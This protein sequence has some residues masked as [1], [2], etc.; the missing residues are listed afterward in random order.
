M[1]NSRAAT[2]RR[3][4]AVLKLIYSKKPN[5]QYANW[6]LDKIFDQAT[7]KIDMP[8]LTATLLQWCFDQGIYPNRLQLSSMLWLIVQRDCVNGQKYVASQNP[9]QLFAQQATIAP[10]T[11]SEPIV[12]F[13]VAKQ[14]YHQYKTSDYHTPIKKIKPCV[15]ILDKCIGP[16]KYPRNQMLSQIH[17]YYVA[18]WRGEVVNYDHTN[19][20]KSYD[21]LYYY[22]NI[23]N[24]AWSLQ[25]W[26][27]NAFVEAWYLTK[28]YPHF[29]E[30]ISY[31]AEHCRA[32]NIDCVNADLF[33][34]TTEQLGRLYAG[35]PAEKH[36]ILR[37][38]Q[39]I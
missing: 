9:S 16:A 27:Q 20:V 15:G 1:S 26:L 13:M 34:A 19:T 24:Y 11:S 10:K 32:N 35:A 22:P 2:L 4:P 7:Y 29:A 17:K 28:K 18:H 33:D 8:E 25:N 21:E 31:L 38:L 37:C 14:V 5:Y 30:D 36:A 3:V 39:I 12:A 6:S 23:A